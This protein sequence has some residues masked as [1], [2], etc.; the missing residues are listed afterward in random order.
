MSDYLTPEEIDEWAD[1]LERTLPANTKTADTLRELLAICEA[2]AEGEIGMLP[3]GDFAVALKM[4]FVRRA[5]KV[6]GL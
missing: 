5:R 1:E 3:Y 2:V 6:M 4:D